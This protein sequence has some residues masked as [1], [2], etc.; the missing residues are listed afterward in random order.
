[1]KR[2]IRA[3]GF[4]SDEKEIMNGIKAVMSTQW[5]EGPYTEEFRKVFG[6]FVNKEFVVPVNSGS[7]ANLLALSSLTSHLLE[8]PIKKGDEIITVAACF[9]TTV[10][11]I[12]QLGCV[13]VFVD[14]DIPTYNVNIEKLKKAISK[15]TKAIILAHTLGNP[16]NI[17]EVKEI[18]NKYKLFLIEDCCDALGSTYNKEPVGTYADL[19]TYSFYPA[20]HITAGEGGAVCTDNPKLN[21]ILNSMRDWGRECHCLPGKDN[22]CGQ[23]FSQKHGNLPKGF[24]HKYVY[25]HIGYNLKWTDIQASIL[26]AQLE[27]LP[28]FIQRRKVNFNSLKEGLKQFSDYIMLPEATDNSEPSWF[29]FPITLRKGIDRN[30]LINYLDK[31]G[32]HT[33]LLFAGNITKQ[34]Y[35]LKSNIKYCVRSSLNNS[36]IIMKQTFWIGVYP[37]ITKTDIDY[38]IDTFKKYKWK[39]K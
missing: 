32:I 18:C 36:D 16:F 27:K 11:P 33:R 20:H 2:E 31:K 13:P 10:N 8:N 34:P 38:I 12:I 15:K 9:P 1:M 39:V 30:D 37:A 5:A 28:E 3:S 35:F 22:S 7:S 24:D 23:R 6:K 21:K 26:L 4:V 14:V 17:N 19:S 25:S 29:G